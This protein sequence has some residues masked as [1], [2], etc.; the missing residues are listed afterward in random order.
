MALCLPNLG[1]HPCTGHSAGVCVKLV[2]AP[3]SLLLIF[4]GSHQALSCHSGCEQTVRIYRVF[5]GPFIY[6]GGSFLA[7]GALRCQIVFIFPLPLGFLRAHH[8]WLFTTPVFPP[9]LN[10][11][12]PAHDSCACVTVRR[13]NRAAGHFYCVFS[14][15]FFSSPPSCT[16]SL[17]PASHLPRRVLPRQQ[18]ATYTLGVLRVSMLSLL[19]ACILFALLGGCVQSYIS[20]LWCWE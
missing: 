7:W 10:S 1:G 6:W 17:G 5:S 19:S 20:H 14:W 12:Q 3:S 2:F 8:S 11:C 16:Q 18:L 15:V 13:T 4:N 9:C